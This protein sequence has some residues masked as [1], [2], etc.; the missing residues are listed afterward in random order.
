[1]GF[2]PQ[3]IGPEQLMRAVVALVGHLAA[4][5][6]VKTDVPMRSMPPAAQLDLMQRGENAGGAAALSRVIIAIDAGEGRGT[7]IDDRRGQ[8][9]AAYA[10]RLTRTPKRR[11]CVL[12]GRKPFRTLRSL[13]SKMEI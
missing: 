2:I 11:D 6:D 3:S 8:Q 9:P 5:V 1:M 12:T 4:A 13:I 10:K 7:D